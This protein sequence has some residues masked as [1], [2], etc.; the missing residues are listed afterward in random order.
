[1]TDSKIV[2]MEN[3]GKCL[4]CGKSFQG[5]TDKK[6]CSDAC[7]SEYHNRLRAKEGNQ[8][9]DVD[10]ILHR[11]REFLRDNLRAGNTVINMN[12]P[13]A[14][15]FNSRFFTSIE[16][17]FLR[18]PIYHCFGYRYYISLGKLHIVD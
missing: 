4:L 17:R 18:P 6:F 8:V 7:R 2:N 15:F 14:A 11:N 9:R 5:R 16:R 10:R 1:M 3:E 12:E 13:I